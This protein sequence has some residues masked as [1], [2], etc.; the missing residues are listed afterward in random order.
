[1]LSDANRLFI[2][3]LHLC[4][5]FASERLERPDRRVSLHFIRTTVLGSQL[6]VS[7]RFL[8]G[9]S[10]PDPTLQYTDSFTVFI[11]KS[12]YD[13]RTGISTHE[14]FQISGSKIQPSV[15]FFKKKITFERNR[16]ID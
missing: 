7:N 4:F 9:L 6:W 12:R 2:Y 3:F 8:I 5:G 13:K 11:K 16:L 15:P 10:D 1:M 14:D